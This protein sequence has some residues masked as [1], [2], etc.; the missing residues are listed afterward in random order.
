MYD[1]VE[2]ND[3]RKEQSFEVITTFD[4]VDDAN[5]VAFQYAMNDMKKIST[6]TNDSFNFQCK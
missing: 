1:V 3:Y 4:D 5:K 2:Y 6:Y